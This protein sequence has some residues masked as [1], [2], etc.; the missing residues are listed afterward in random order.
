M[1]LSAQITGIKQ[2]ERNL[3]S[4]VGKRTQKIINQTN[5]SAI[6]VDRQA[7]KNAPVDTGRL[8]TSIHAIPTSTFDRETNVMT[9]DVEAAVATN[10]E[11]APFL[12]FGTVKIDARPFMFPAWESERPKYIEALRKITRLKEEV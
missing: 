6:N 2:F 1:S 12:E 4:A 5:A 9:G 8:R 3:K 10:V 7:K 11:Y